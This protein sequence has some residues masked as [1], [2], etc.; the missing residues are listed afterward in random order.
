MTEEQ[1]KMVMNLGLNL[2]AYLNGDTK[3]SMPVT[4]TEWNLCRLWEEENNCIG[5]LTFWMH[6]EYNYE[7]LYNLLTDEQKKLALDFQ[8]DESFGPDDLKR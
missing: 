7:G 2:S 6:V 1:T 8:E 4:E 5:D 3:R